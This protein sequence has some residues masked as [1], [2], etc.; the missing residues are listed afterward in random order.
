MYIG[1]KIFSI[2]FIIIIIF[3]SIYFFYRIYIADT[4][5]LHL[6]FLPLLLGLIIEYWRISRD[7]RSVLF[8][9]LIAYLLSLINFLPYKHEKEYTLVDH[10]EFWP[11][12]FI[13]FFIFIALIFQFTK[14]TK[15]LTEGITLLLTLSINYWILSNDYWSSEYIIVKILIIINGL[16]SIYSIFHS[17]SNKIHSKSSVFL[18]SIWSS[19]ITLI[20]SIDNFLKIYQNIDIENM[21]SFSQSLFTFLQFFFLGISSIYI[22]QNIVM[23]GAFVPH[24][25]YFNTIRDIAEVHVQ[26]YSNIQVDFFDALLVFVITLLVFTLNY[27]YQYLPINFM[28]WCV[29]TITPYYLFLLNSILKKNN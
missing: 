28:I 20:L 17:L 27:R 19:I 15:K 21:A 24:K 25:D 26:R 13:G 18:L 3:I 4:Q 11:F 9:T 29:I 8:T 10:L 22:A 6:Y 23:V 2:I 14:A 1:G 12:L 16:F 7:F 5:I